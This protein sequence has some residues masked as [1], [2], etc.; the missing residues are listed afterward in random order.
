[1]EYRQ[2]GRSGLRISSL[3]LGTMGFGGTG[4]AE[5]VGTIDVDGAR[6]QIDMAREAGVN[7]VDT[8]DVYS[9]G[10][11]EEILGQ[12]LGKN[13]DDVL[14]ATKVRMPMGSGP[15]D[16]GLSRH[17]VISGCEASLRRL[18]TDRIDLY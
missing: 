1:M 18:N 8:A 16:A 12:A 4:W 11:S 14:I 13:R 5:A 2:L 10:L 3:T 6:T 7:L 15:N 9:A 17:H